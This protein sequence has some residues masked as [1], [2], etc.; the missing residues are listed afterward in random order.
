[1]EV[2]ERI[3]AIAMD[4]DGVL[5]DGTFWWGANNEELKRFSFADV[6]GMGLALQAGLKLALVSGESS[7]AGMALVRRYAE[8][9]KIADVYPGCHD[10]AAAFRDFTAKHG[11]DPRDAC[12]IGDDTIDMPAMDL[13][14]LAV[15]PPNAQADVRAKAA[16]VTKLGGGHGAVREVIDLILDAQAARRQRHG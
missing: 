9:L 11:I 3:K 2:I 6:T 12:F 8:K 13:A 15:A 1:M 10:K 5:T 7:P 14:G 4:V 16:L